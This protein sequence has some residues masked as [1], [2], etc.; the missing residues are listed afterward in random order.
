MRVA[1]G[2]IAK[3][4][5]TELG[6]ETANHVLVFGGIEVAVPETMSFADIKKVAEASDLSI[7]NPKQE[8]TIKAHIDQ[9]K[10]KEIRLVVLL[11]HSFMAY[12]QA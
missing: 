2:A 10:K 3:A 1:V 11:K 12:Q 4:I 8:A 7:V 6:I 9:V 5:L